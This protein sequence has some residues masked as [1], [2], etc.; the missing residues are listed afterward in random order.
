MGSNNP[1]TFPKI[2]RYQMRDQ[3]TPS[4]LRRE[5]VKDEQSEEVMDIHCEFYIKDEFSEPY[6]PNSIFCI[7]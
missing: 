4:L 5:N 7:L 2:Y 6:H 3:G 1:T